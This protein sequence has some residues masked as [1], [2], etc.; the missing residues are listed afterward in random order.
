[1]TNPNLKDA[2]KALSEALINEEQIEGATGDLPNAPNIETTD[3][4]LSLPELYQQ[5]SIPSL[6]ESVLFTSKLDGATGAIFNIKKND[7]GDGIV[8]LR[9]DV[10][11]YPSKP[12]KSEIT[13][14]AVEDIMKQFGING[15]KSISEVLRGLSNDDKNTKLLEFLQLHAVKED[16]TLQLTSSNAKDT[17][18]ELTKRIAKSVLS[19]NTKGVKTYRASI[20]LPYELAS[21]VM[22]Y[23]DNFAKNLPSTTTYYVGGNELHDF[24]INPIATDKNIYIILNDKYT[25][26]KSAGVFAPYQD[27]IKVSVDPESGQPVYFIFNRFAMGISPLHTVDDPSIKSF[28][29]V[30]E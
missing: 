29:F 16:E 24:Y 18:F 17:Y 15:V 23:T 19:M 4:N 2:I 1:M 27:E 30:G 14:E 26:G 8:L 9:N 13:T 11:V 12:I 10:E 20:I 28:T 3:Q 25:Q 22:G 6:A 7:E 21:I 5:L